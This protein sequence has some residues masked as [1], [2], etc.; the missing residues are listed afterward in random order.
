MSVYNTLLTDLVCPHCGARSA[1]RADFRFGLRDQTD[2]C[3]GDL[4][5]WE[6]RGVASPRRRP[7]DGD[8]VGEAYTECPNCGKPVWLLIRVERDRIV[9]ADVDADREDPDA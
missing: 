1:V 8:F 2:Y 5:I 3:V 9:A 4:V 6:G 7:P